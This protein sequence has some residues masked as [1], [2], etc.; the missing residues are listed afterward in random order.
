MAS[1]LLLVTRL[2]PGLSVTAQ[3]YCRAA[4]RSEIGLRRFNDGSSD[5]R[6]GKLSCPPKRFGEGWNR[7]F[8]FQLKGSTRH[9]RTASSPHSTGT[10]NPR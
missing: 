6:P 8:S 7:G 9:T 10:V 1:C 3:S 2:H 5:A 4:R